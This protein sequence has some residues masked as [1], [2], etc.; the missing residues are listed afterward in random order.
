MSDRE[1][2]G[3]DDLSLPKATVQKIINEILASPD[4]EPSLA[5]G[6]DARD[7]LI[8]CCVEFITLISSEANDIAEKDSKKTIATEHIDKALREL[9]FPEYVREVL[10]SAGEMKESLKTR[11][12]KTSKMDQSGLTQEE[13]LEQQQ[14]LFRSATSKFNQES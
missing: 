10:A 12:K 14:A 13:L 6:K 8:D 3:T 11:E 7:L 1:F 5:F 4:S 2:G 9:G